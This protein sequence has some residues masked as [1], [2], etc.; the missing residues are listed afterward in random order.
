MPDAPVC[1][2]YASGMSDYRRYSTTALEVA[3]CGGSIACV[4]AL[5][6]AGADPSIGDPLRNAV[7]FGWLDIVEVLIDRGADVNLAKENGQTYLHYAV[8]GG[9]SKLSLEMIALLLRKGARVD[10]RDHDGRT[11]LDHAEACLG[12]YQS[13][14]HLRQT[15]ILRAAGAS[16]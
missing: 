12:P 8:F 16:G 2:L 14:A 13:E 6:D 1:S 11:A 4:K 15:E 9:A 7:C 10:M 5:L 3:A